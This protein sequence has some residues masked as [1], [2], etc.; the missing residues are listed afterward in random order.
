LPHPHIEKRDFVL[1][2]LV[3]LFG[4]Q[5]MDGFSRSFQEMLNA[6]QRNEKV[7]I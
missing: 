2:L 7:E 4:N 3:E 6:L 5:V 1:V